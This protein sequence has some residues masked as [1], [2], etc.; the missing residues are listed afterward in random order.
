MEVRVHIRVSSSD[1]T[2]LVCS[3]LFQ[4][5][6]LASEPPESVRLY[7]PLTRAV[8]GDVPASIFTLVLGTGTQALMLE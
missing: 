7:F 6:W 3:L 5:D 1:S 4:L 2:E 8:E